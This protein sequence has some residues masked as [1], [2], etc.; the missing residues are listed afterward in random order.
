MDFQ[1]HDFDPPF[2]YS[3]KK[4]GQ[5]Y[6]FCCAGPGED[7]PFDRGIW[8]FMPQPSEVVVPIPGEED[9]EMPETCLV[10]EDDIEPLIKDLYDW[11]CGYS[12]HGKGGKLPEFDSTKWFNIA[13]WIEDLEKLAAQPGEPGS[14]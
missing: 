13:P 3:F 9:G 11:A 4:H 10:S 8:A 14:A 6:V 12:E 7:G 2:G 5:K 1:I